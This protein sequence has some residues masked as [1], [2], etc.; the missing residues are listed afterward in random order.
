MKNLITALAYTLMLPLSLTAQ[1]TFLKT[2]GGPGDEVANAAIE[3]IDGMEAPL[4][5]EISARLQASLL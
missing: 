5:A 2:I 4:P 3:T 1:N